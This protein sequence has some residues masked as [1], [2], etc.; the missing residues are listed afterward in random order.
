MAKLQTVSGPA[1]RKSAPV[2]VRVID[3]GNTKNIQGHVPSLPDRDQRIRE[4][5]YGYFVERGRAGGHDLDDWLKAEA[6]IEQFMR[7]EAGST[8]GA[9]VEQ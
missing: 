4:V 7:G 8:A 5:A 6:Q 3:A 9:T 1:A 2:E